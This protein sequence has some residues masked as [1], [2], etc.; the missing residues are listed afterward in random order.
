M[1]VEC[2]V[3][4][5]S[6][7]HDLMSKISKREGQQKQCP[8]TTHVLTSKELTIS[9]WVYL[10]VKSRLCWNIKKYRDP[11]FKQPTLPYK[12]E[13]RYWC[14]SSTKQI[15]LATFQT[16]IYTQAEFLNALGKI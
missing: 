5:Y 16:S 6:I 3:F 12:L 4:D 7:S 11:K 13:S 1:T 15:I 2:L 9:C 10:E 14:I 8:P